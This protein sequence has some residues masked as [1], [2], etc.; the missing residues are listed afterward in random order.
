[1]K[2][3][4]LIDKLVMRGSA[5]N[6]GSF[7][8]RCAENSERWG[9]ASKVKLCWMLADLDSSGAESVSAPRLIICDDVLSGH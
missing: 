4:G 5:I 2:L 8:N 7:N 1:M 3:P 6:R 9:H